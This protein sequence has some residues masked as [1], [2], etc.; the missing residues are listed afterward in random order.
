MEGPADPDGIQYGLTAA[1][2]LDPNHNGGLDHT[3]IQGSLTLLF[4]LSSNYLPYTSDAGFATLFSNFRY[5]F[6]TALNEPH[7]G[8]PLSVAA[9]APSGI[10]LFGV[11][12]VCL[13][14]F[15]YW[16]KRR[17]TKMA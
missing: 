15:S 7:L 2:G 1:V 5:Q 8:D 12:G 10:V 17:M 16:S 6:G 13:A 11:A 4:N 3:L 9:P 14:A